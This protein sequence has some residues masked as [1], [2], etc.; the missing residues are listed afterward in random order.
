MEEEGF[1]LADVIVPHHT[2]SG[3]HT[4]LSTALRYALRT[5]P[6]CTTL[7][8][9]CMVLIALCAFSLSE[10]GSGRGSTCRQGEHLG[11]MRRATRRS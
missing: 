3:H 11:E 9:A 5:A 6:H 4:V 2:A 1:G 10:A 8:Y 7:R